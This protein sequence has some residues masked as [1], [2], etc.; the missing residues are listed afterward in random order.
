MTETKPITLKAHAK[1]NLGLNITGKRTDGFHELDTLFVRLEL[2]DTIELEPRPEGIVLEIEGADLPTDSNNLAY[3]AAA[4]YLEAAGQGEGVHIRLTKNIPIAAGL[5]GGSSDAAAVLRSLAQLYPAEID[6]MSL[7]LALGS[8]V[9]FFVL[10]E[11]AAR[12]RGRGERLEPVNIPPLHFVLI[13]PGIH[14]S[15][16]AAYGNLK[17]FGESLELKPLIESLTTATPLYTNS[18]QAG[19]LALEPEIGKVLSVLE[20]TPL[21]GVTMSGSGSTCFGL[22][23]DDM[24]AL[25]IAKDL[26]DRCP[27]WWVCSS[28]AV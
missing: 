12:G 14:V 17:S 13:N 26:R 2:H 18:L 19:V 9:P 16:S 20:A 23:E 11:V 8:D 24:E 5:G 22:A 3:K 27:E 10:D 4:V 25:E 15:A 1:V 7:A 28:A 21:R 6:L